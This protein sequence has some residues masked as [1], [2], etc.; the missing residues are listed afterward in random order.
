MGELADVLE[1]IEAK[2]KG[3]TIIYNA[4]DEEEIINRRKQA[5]SRPVVIYRLTEEERLAVI[6][7][8]GPPMD[9][10]KA[11][12]IRRK[13]RGMVGGFLSRKEA[14]TGNVDTPGCDED[15]ANLNEKEVVST[16]RL[17]REKTIEKYATWL[18][19]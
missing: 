10:E 16:E 17:V 12:W 19:K 5:E 4:P 6:A 13:Y 7:K 9:P 8:Y 2:L 14:C 1:Q 11:A 18:K 3:G 15:R